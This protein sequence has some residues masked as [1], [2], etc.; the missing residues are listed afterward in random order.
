M[1]AEATVGQGTHDVAQSSQFSDSAGEGRSLGRR[2]IVLARLPHVGAA[3][4]SARTA[5]LESRGTTFSQSTRFYLDPQHVASSTPESAPDEPSERQ[6]QTT[7]HRRHHGAH[8]RPNQEHPDVGTSP[9][10]PFATGM[11]ALPGRIASHSGLIVTLAVAASVVLLYWMIIMPSRTPREDF[12]TSY[13]TYGATEIEIPQ[14]HA[15][16]APS[17]EPEPTPAAAKTESIQTNQA[18]QP[19]DDRPAA[20]VAQQQPTPDLTAPALSEPAAA[21]PPASS[22]IMQPHE[23]KPVPLPPDKDEPSTD[24]AAG[25]TDSS[26]AAYP[27]TDHPLA[28]D[29]TVLSTVDS[30]PNEG[31]MYLPVPQVARQPE[32][33]TLF[34]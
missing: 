13:D 10:R 20:V 17:S 19:V 7:G 14:F 16:E 27:T 29:W 3:E 1:P 9:Q 6:R 5:P 24:T 31:A 11:V 28:C 26:A 2:P 12:G 23:T 8:R 22:A 33:P 32:S 25:Y 30:S 4:P 18:A 34:R 15:P 21:S